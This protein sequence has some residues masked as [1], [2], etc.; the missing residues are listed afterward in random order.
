ME[1][2]ILLEHLMGMGAQIATVFIAFMFY[3]VKKEV[4]V[5]K[6]EIKKLEKSMGDF[7]VRVSV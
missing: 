6:D 1:P 7:Y 4:S 2:V 5:L 3:D